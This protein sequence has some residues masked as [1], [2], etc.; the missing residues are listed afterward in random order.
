MVVNDLGLTPAGAGENAVAAEVETTGG[1]TVAS[2]DSVASWEGARRIVATAL[3]AFGRVDAVVSNAGY[4]R[5]VLFHKMTE[6]DF[7]L[8]CSPGP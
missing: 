4:L 8:R 6:E 1:R 2:R 3:D 5:D 7:D